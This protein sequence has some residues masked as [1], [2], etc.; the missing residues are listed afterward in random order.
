MDFEFLGKISSGTF[1]TVHKVQEKV[2]HKIMALKLIH[3]HFQQE[4]TRIQRGFIS[5]SKVSHVNCVR[6]FEWI[7]NEKEFGFLMEFIDGKPISVLKNSPLL[8]ILQVLIQVCNGLDALHKHKLVH[9]DLKPQNILINEDEKV[10]ITDFDLIKLDD[11]STLTTTGAF[12][13]TVKYSSPEQCK[14]ATKIDSRSDLYS[15]GVIFYELLTGNVPFNGTNFAEI[16]LAHLRSPLVSPKQFVPDLPETIEK[17]IK[18]LLEK[19]PKNRF[20]TAREVAFELNNFL[21]QSDAI[22]LE[23]LGDFLL[24]PIFV[25][26]NEN[27]RTLENA[28]TE[29]TSEKGKVIFISGE[30]G[31]GKT[32]LWEEFRIGLSY[33]KAQIFET[34]CQKNGNVYEPLQKILLKTID[35]LSSKSNPEKAEMLGKFAWDLVKIAPE[36]SKMRFFQI[37][38]KQTEPDEKNIRLFD[39]LANFFKKLAFE[40]N[41][42]ILFFDDL[43][44]IDEASCKCL[45]FLLRALKNSPVLFAGTFRQEEFAQSKLPKLFTETENIA[46]ILVLKPLEVSAV[47]EMLTSMLGKIDP[48]NTRFAMEIFKQTEGNPLFIHEIMHHLVET[49]KLHRKNGNWDVDVETFSELILPQSIHQVIYERLKSIETELYNILEIASVIGKNFDLKTLAEAINLPNN[50]IIRKLDDARELRLVE[51]LEDTETYVFI[52]DAIRETL[53]QNLSEN[54][55]QKLHNK[56]GEILEKSENPEIEKLAFHFYSSQNK[57]K[58]F[59]FCS[60][61]GNFALKN[62]A[63][64]NALIYFSKALENITPQNNFMEK[65]DLTFHKSDILQTTGKIDDALVC[66]DECL[67]IANENDFPFFLADYEK[68]A[69]VIFWRKGEF[70][71]ALEFYESSLKR[72]EKRSDELNSVA[73]ISNIGL[74]HAARG[75]YKQAMECYEKKLKIS[76]ESGNLLEISKTI[77]K[78][79]EVQRLLDNYEEAT[80]LY[81]KQLKIAE[82]NGFKTE[83]SNAS[84]NIALVFYT[85]GDFEKALEFTEKQLKIDESIGNKEG[86]GRAFNELGN[87]FW[88]KGDYKKAIYFY[89][90]CI[91]I[92]DEINNKIISSAAL[93]NVGILQMEEGNYEQSI[94]TLTKALNFN[95]KI[96][97]KQLLAVINGNIAEAFTKQNSFEKALEFYEKSITFS[98]ELK[99]RYLLSFW[100]IDKARILFYLKDFSQ[101]E[102]FA[103]EGLNFAN[104]IQNHEQIF[105]GKVLLAKIYFAKGDKKQAEKELTNLLE[106]TENET[107]KAELHYELWQLTKNEEHSRKAFSLYKK[108]YEKTPNIEFKNRFTE[109]DRRNQKPFVSEIQ[110]LHSELLISLVQF[111]NPETAFSELLRFL[112]EKCEANSCEILVRNQETNEFEISAISPNLKNDEIDFSQSI[113]MKSIEKNE[114]LCIENAVESPD[115]NQ[116]VSILGKP[117][118]S[119]ITVPMRVNNTLHGALYLDRKNF[120]LG[121]FSEKDLENVQ[122]IADVLT[123]LLIRQEELRRF[124]VQAKINNLGMFTGN[125][126][127]MQ[128]VYKQIEKAARTNSTVY[129]YGESGTG[130]ELVSRALH[131]LSSRCSKPFIPVNCAAIPK[132]LAESEFFGHEK[133]A[134]SGAIFSKRG[135][136][137]LADGGTLLLDEIA[138]LPLELQAKLL[139]VIQDREIWK[140]GGQKSVP[141]NIKII[142]ATNKDLEEEVA[143]GSFRQDLFYRL[144]VLKINLPPL[145]ERQEDISLLAYYFLGKFKSEISGFTTESL[146]A[147]QENQW[148][149]NIR[150][151]ENLIEKAVVQHEG[152]SPITLRELFPQK[153][154]LKQKQTEQQTIFPGQ[155]PKGANLDEK[156]AISE[157]IIVIE[158]LENNLGNKSKTASELGITRMRLDRIVERHQLEFEKKWTKNS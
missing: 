132:D 43:Q 21:S 149:G 10:K 70:E 17:I 26:R 86:M 58:A 109:L 59:K 154:S 119:V 19:N 46:E 50:K 34:S 98:Q 29:T 127:K 133:G 141:V 83:I 152:T 100:L 108:L 62:F 79:A 145:R 42:L 37:I 113:L 114:P 92:S 140:V 36:L 89:E 41:T 4:K 130:K 135:K 134:F 117:F 153:V 64:E 129:V 136:F 57:P 72:Y 110:N 147:L 52:H 22:E 93:T 91:K 8:K 47:S 151:L 80:K 123:P 105:K 124:R 20:Q 142:V 122:K 51:I 74:V 1:G 120:E 7:E 101:A 23:T 94:L 68:S 48:V 155:F 35:S 88:K 144:N 15:L 76:E 55:R 77:G 106:K 131:E 118:L 84:G 14:D 85:K 75:D 60:L 18:K 150:E 45:S 138:E 115:F 112:T 139:R 61:A 126:K 33:Q 90:K 158:S 2:N 11:A 82:E 99:S 137:E 31:I 95:E 6:M 24:P 87:I 97:N 71:K 32:K 107:E 9:R 56:I 148:L 157:K 81:E 3:P 13:G 125:S 103:L 38:N 53:L 78:I 63:Y 146:L 16:G 54:A 96:G 28:F 73:V 156:L 65:L 121:P 39:T 5:A 69:G 111:L 116:N 27:L 143:K 66:L 128:E 25:G 30:S 44:W 102:I 40:G 67:K 49:K 12:I 104:E